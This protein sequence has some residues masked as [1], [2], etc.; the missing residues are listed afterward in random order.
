M[1][2]AAILLR[3]ALYRKTYTDTARQRSGSAATG[4]RLNCGRR[5]AAAGDWKLE[6][7]AASR[8]SCRG[9]LP[10]AGASQPPRQ[11]EAQ[12][13][14]AR[15]GVGATTSGFEGGVSEVGV[16]PRAVVADCGAGSSVRR[17][18]LDHDVRPGVTA[19]GFN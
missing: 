2:C 18:P 12:S 13:G 15:G 16:K 14:A 10:A 1:P 17:R 4:W 9:D 8:P 19:R 5:P 3:S 6:G 7:E 11:R